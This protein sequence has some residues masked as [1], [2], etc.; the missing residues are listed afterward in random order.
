MG[1]QGRVS[2]PFSSGAVA[3]SICGGRS[4]AKAVKTRSPE[5]K[6]SPA[7]PEKG[8]LTR[9]RRGAPR[10]EPAAS[11]S[12]NRMGTA[13]NLRVAVPERRRRCSYAVL[14]EGVG[15][16]SWRKLRKTGRAVPERFPH[17]EAQW[18]LSLRRPL[19]SP[20]APVRPPSAP[21]R[22]GVRPRR[23]APG[24][25]IEAG[26]SPR[27]SG[28]AGDP[29]TSESL[30]STAPRGTPR[31]APPTKPQALRKYGVHPALTTN[32]AKLP[33]AWPRQRHIR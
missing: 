13:A 16:D 24:R 8:E 32:A 27:I 20:L 12:A 11:G 31:A 21:F 6:V 1:C 25:R 4:A 18:M 26:W 28:G 3:W 15:E 23:P 29:L 30:A 7:P 9:P 5:V 17:E 14:Q 22:P 33:P 10:A 19:R 2:S